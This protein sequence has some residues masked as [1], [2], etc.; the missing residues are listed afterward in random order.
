MS[1]KAWFLQVDDGSGRRDATPEE[2]ADFK[3][4]PPPRVFIE[5]P[6]VLADGYVAQS[7]EDEA[8]HLAA[9]EPVKPAPPV[10]PAPDPLDEVS[11][12][13]DDP[14]FDEKSKGKAAKKK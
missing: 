13:M 2:T 11:V 9:I 8:T 7:A 6:K 5:Y 14:A 3:A 4:L 10:T 12:E 1:D